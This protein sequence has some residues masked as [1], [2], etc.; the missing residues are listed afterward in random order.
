MNTQATADWIAMT[1]IGDIKTNLNIT[2]EE[3]M[4]II[5]RKYQM[6]VLYDR[7]WMGRENARESI[8]ENIEKSYDYVM[9]LMLELLRRN[10]E[11]HA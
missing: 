8:Y 1:I 11:S 2:S 10:L 3:I 5:N 6:K 4:N 9:S 7:A